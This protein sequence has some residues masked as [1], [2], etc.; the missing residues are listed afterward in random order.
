MTTV[1][2]LVLL[3]GAIVGA[4]VVLNRIRGRKFSMLYPTGK[5]SCLE[6]FPGIANVGEIGTCMGQLH[7]VGKVRFGNT[8]VD[9]IA[10]CTVIEAGTKVE[11][12]ERRPNR[13]IVRVKCEES[14]R[15]TSVEE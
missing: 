11:V 10:E 5:S 2:I 7:P 13:V 12:I 3:V 8:L 6:E 9:A 15:C 4:I 1:L 14:P